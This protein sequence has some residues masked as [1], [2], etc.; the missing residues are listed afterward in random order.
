[1]TVWKTRRSQETLQNGIATFFRRCGIKAERKREREKERKKERK[2]EKK[3]GKKV[4]DAGHYIPLLDSQFGSRW[5]VCA[6][7]VAFIHFEF[8]MVCMRSE[9]RLYSF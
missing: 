6:R 4:L 5:Y 9:C 2:K 1:M 3:K 7:N 8:K